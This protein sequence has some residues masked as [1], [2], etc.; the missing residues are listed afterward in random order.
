MGPDPLDA[1]VFFKRAE[2]ILAD[3]EIHQKFQAKVISP[4]LSVKARAVLAK[5]STHV[6][7][8]Y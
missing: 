7:N 4:F 3:Y 8:D 5:L 2:Q 1:T 6:T